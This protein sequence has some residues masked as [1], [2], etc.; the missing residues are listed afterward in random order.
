MWSA[1]SLGSLAPENWAEHLERLG[2]AG[3]VYNVASNCELRKRD[4]NNLEFVLAE[5]PESSHAELP[6]L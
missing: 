1:A 2:L 4:G 3:L 6:A 5:L